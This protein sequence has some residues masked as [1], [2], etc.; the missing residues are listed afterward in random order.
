MKREKGTI[1][2]NKRTEAKEEKLK[3]VKMNENTT[4]II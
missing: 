4:R 1:D 2:G 3:T